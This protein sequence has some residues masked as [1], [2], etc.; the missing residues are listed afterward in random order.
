MACV[1][2]GTRRESTLGLGW[3]ELATCCAAAS[4]FFLISSFLVSSV[5]GSVPY[6]GGDGNYQCQCQ[7]PT[8][9]R[10]LES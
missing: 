8:G 5:S 1:A 4:Y 2:E 6:L 10:W 7:S 3:W 9:R